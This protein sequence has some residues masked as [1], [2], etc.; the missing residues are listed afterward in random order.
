MNTIEQ[1]PLNELSPS[2]CGVVC[3]ITA[4][5]DEIERLMAMGVC[6]D[7]VIELVQCGDPLIL[8]VFG[9]RIGVSARLADR[10][11][12]HPCRPTHCY[13]R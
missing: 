7:R 3:R 6:V 12:V 10:I 2:Q 9:T 13:S 5:D 4:L 11:L 8:R 1:V